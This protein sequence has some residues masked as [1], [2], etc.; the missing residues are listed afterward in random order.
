[1]VTVFGIPGLLP[2][3]VTTNPS[4]GAGAFTVTVPTR[5]PTPPTTEVSAKLTPV[6]I[7]R[8]VIVRFAEAVVPAKLAVTCNKPDVA[9]GA[10][11]RVLVMV[12]VAVV[13]PTG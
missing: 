12:K 3:S 10:G 8:R 4:D 9:V 5:G 7:I 1:M 11:R 13:C 6:T 2:L